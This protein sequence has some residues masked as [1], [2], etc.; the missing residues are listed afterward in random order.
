MKSSVVIGIGSPFGADVLGWRV[1]EA[2]RARREFQAR[3]ARDVATELCDRPGSNLLRVLQAYDTAIVVDA[4]LS[5][6]RAGSVRELD[7]D[8]LPATAPTSS[9][10]FGLASA[11]HLGRALHQ[12]PVRLIV[13]GVELAKSD[14]EFDP[15]EAVTRILYRLDVMAE[16][17]K[18]AARARIA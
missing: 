15:S 17:E 9:H 2:L 5:G 1:V 18:P 7:L 16:A 4:M 8:E 12:L 14:A 3:H 6:A 11:L 13:M 10:G